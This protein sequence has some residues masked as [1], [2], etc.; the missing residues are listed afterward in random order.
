MNGPEAKAAFDLANALVKEG[1]YEAA[2]AV[3]MLPS[4]RKLIEKRI[5]ESSGAGANSAKEN[6]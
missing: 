3:E 1:K 5:A 6:K 2:L 4:D